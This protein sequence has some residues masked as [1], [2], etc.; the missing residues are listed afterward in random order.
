MPLIGDGLLT[1]VQLSRRWGRKIKVG[2][3]EQGR[4]LKKGP[5]FVKVGT[6]RAAA[7]FYR[8]ADVIEYERKHTVKAGK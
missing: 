1:P 3:L 5:A 4:A 2:T 8:I 6:L 7:V